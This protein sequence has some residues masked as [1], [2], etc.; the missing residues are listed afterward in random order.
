MGNA[1]STA[2]YFRMSLKVT[3]CVPLRSLYALVSSEPTPSSTERSRP[4]RLATM[5]VWPPNVGMP[6]RSCV[7]VSKNM[8]PPWPPTYHWKLPLPGSWA[9]TESALNDSARAATGML[10]ESMRITDC[11]RKV[12]APGGP[13][14]LPR[15]QSAVRQN[16]WNV[17][18]SAGGEGE[19]WRRYLLVY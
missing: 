8:T 3:V 10:R 18:E 1:M 13:W 7:G 15:P 6:V 14:R 2:E 12:S 19:R 4:V 11:L 5:R 17:L 16:A 9:A